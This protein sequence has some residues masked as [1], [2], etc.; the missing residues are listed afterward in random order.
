AKIIKR[1]FQESVSGI[2]CRAIAERL[3]KEGIKPFGKSDRWKSASVEKILGNR[4]VLGEYQMY[5]MISAKPFRR[6]PVGDPEPGYFPIII[7]Q[8]LFDRAQAAKESRKT[9]SPKRGMIGKGGNKGHVANL[10]SG[11]AICSYCEAKMYYVTKT[12]HYLTCSKNCEDAKN[13]R[14][15]HFE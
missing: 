15:D 14:Y 1:I 5:K 2:G 6:E 12:Y 7:P 11:I 8:T 10:F 3:F 13:W 4:A 9:W